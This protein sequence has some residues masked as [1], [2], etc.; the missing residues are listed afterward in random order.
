MA[1]KSCKEKG[2][3]SL[4]HGSKRL[5]RA[6]EEQNEDVSLPKQPLRSFGLCW[7]M[8]L[9]GECNL[10]TMREFLANWDQ[11]ERSNQVKI[12]GKTVNFSLEHSRALY[13]V[14]LGFMESLDDDDATDEEQARVNS[15]F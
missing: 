4:S 13:R 9:E 14:G 11:E 6:N 15:N 10:N 8:E 12:R 1:P 3:A 2:V 7:V 5:R